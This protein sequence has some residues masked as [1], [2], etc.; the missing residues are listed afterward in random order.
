[1]NDCDIGLAAGP[2]HRNSALPRELTQL[3]FAELPAVLSHQ[4]VKFALLRFREAAGV[5][6]GEAFGEALAPDVVEET[7]QAAR[8]LDAQW[9]GLD[10]E[11]VS[12]LQAQHRGGRAGCGEVGPLDRLSS[13]QVGQGLGVDGHDGHPVARLD[14]ACQFGWREISVSQK[15]V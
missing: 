14:K 11:Q 10:V 5:L 9:D 6:E 4:F 13:R 7:L 3:S 12:N 1:M 2:L 15:L 8:P